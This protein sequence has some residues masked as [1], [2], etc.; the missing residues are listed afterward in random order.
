[1]GERKKKKAEESSDDGGANFMMMFNAL[2]IIILAFFILL[3]TL[4]EIDESKKKEALGSLAGAFG[5][6]MG[7]NEQDKAASRMNRS[8]SV[9]QD[10]RVIDSLLRDLR[11]LI[12][13]KKLGDPQDVGLDSGGLYPRLRL[14]SHL[15]Y[16]PGG[17]EITPKAFPSH[18]PFIPSS[19]QSGSSLQQ[20]K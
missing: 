15:L 10:M 1:M 9:T 11:I 17:I 14:A 8:D 20:S 18:P 5:V 12:K 19:E 4:A 13:D 16:R 2:M 3:N 7:G 6:L